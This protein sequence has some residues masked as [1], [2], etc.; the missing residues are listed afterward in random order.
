MCVPKRSTSIPFGTTSYVPGE[1]LHHVGL[2]RFRNADLAVQTIHQNREVRLE[3]AVPGIGVPGGMEGG[4]IHGAGIEQHHVGQQ[5]RQRLVTVDDVE[6]LVL[7]DF[8]DR[9][10]EG[11]V[12][13][14]P[15]F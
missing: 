3:H 1:V 7:Q 2:R 6:V 15:G 12:E 9:V 14:Q 10:V 8:L 5:R 11:D 4:H 13:H